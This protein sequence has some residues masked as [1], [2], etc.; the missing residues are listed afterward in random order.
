V[1]PLIAEAMRKAAIAWLTVG[2]RPAFAVW[3]AWRD[4]ALYVVSGPGE[5]RA[6]GLAEARTATVSARGDHGGLIVSFPAAVERVE[7]GG[8]KWEAVAAALASQ[9]LNGPP[10]AVN[11]WAQECVISRLVPVG[12]NR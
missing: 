7:P 9:R 5:Q 8:A 10:D 12:V 11:R 3:C 4:D 1:D 6:P 2:I